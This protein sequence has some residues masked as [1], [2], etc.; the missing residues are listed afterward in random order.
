MTQDEWVYGI[1]MGIGAFFLIMVAV[2]LGL[3]FGLLLGLFT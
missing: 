2:L 3:F 1:L